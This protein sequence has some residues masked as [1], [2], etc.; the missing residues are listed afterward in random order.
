MASR[1]RFVIFSGANERA[2]IACCRYFSRKNILF[3]IVARPS[4]DKIFLTSYKKNIDFSREF[5]YLDAEDITRQIFL[6][7][8]RYTE[9]TLIYLPT[10]ESLNRIMLQYRNEFSSA[11]LVINLC[12]EALYEMLSDKLKFNALA[13]E[14]GILLPPAVANPSVQT[15]PFVAKPK[16]EFSK[17][18][19]EKIYPQL[20][21]SQYQIAD[22]YAK[23]DSDDFFFQKYID[24]KSYY[25]LLF[26]ADNTVKILWQK[27]V[28]QQADGKSIIAAEICV[29]PDPDFEF[30][31]INILQKVNYEGFIMVE[32]MH[33]A[34]HSYLIEANPRLWGPFQLAV[35]NGFNPEWIRF[36]GE[37]VNVSQKKGLYFWL[38]G[39]LINFS[40]GKHIRHFLPGKKNAVQ[41]VFKAICADIYVHQDS[42]MLFLSECK[43][44][45][46]LFFKRKFSARRNNDVTSRIN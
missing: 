20:I 26:L 43:T 30:K 29:C 12:G 36:N 27:N 24:G 9:D 6:L 38:A 45:I 44:A 40:E 10:S 1:E 31:M 4:K 33:D 8:R 22:F 23:F 11:G 3:S 28:L 25:L 5:D 34:G 15:L 2:I 39:L 18:N 42:F 41:Y 7:R 32:L 17:V 37:Y 16:Q 14:N 19:G 46:K 21:F 35:D 13:E